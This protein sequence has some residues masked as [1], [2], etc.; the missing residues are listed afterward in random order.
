M[1]AVF[2]RGNSLSLRRFPPSRT[3]VPISSKEKQFNCAWTLKGL[4]NVGLLSQTHCPNNRPLY[5][6]WCPTFE[7]RVECS[8][9]A[10]R[11][12]ECRHDALRCSKYTVLSTYHLLQLLNMRGLSYIHSPWS[13]V[14]LVVRVCTSHVFISCSCGTMLVA[15]NGQ[16]ET[17]GSGYV[18]DEAGRQQEYSRV[19][20]SGVIDVDAIDVED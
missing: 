4:N 10:N 17:V 18:R 16:F 9:C 7:I 6:W 20:D 3:T 1:L 5:V 14:L 12:L 15:T 2:A 19:G 8:S 13:L 11:V